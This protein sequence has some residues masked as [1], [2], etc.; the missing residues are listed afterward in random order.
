MT[1]DTHT[2]R[3]ASS[4]ES[5]LS[6]FVAGAT[7][8]LLVVYLVG[9]VFYQPLYVW[10]SKY[11]GPIETVQQTVLFAGLLLCIRASWWNRAQRE[12][13]VVLG[14]LSFGLFFAL[15]EELS[16][17]QHFFGFQTPAALEAINFQKEF[18]L[19]NLNALQRFRHFVFLS[20]A[21]VPLVLWG[22]QRRP[23]S[24]WLSRWIDRPWLRIPT[25]MIFPLLVAIPT[26][27]AKE[28]QLASDWG[29]YPGFHIDSSY[30]L[31]VLSRFEEV[32]ELTIYLALLVYLAA[33]SRGSSTSDRL[34]PTRQ[35][36]LRR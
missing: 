23:R 34:D 31:Q 18:N 16:W 25:G 35:P 10:I 22:L 15:G 27:I 32:G 20:A 8:V 4:M 24:P 6:R 5:A 2:V 13:A 36:A 21:I 17:G 28:I 12:V 29:T 33:L 11:E 14:V 7:I 9:L 26:Q 19:H 1:K 3:A 30:M